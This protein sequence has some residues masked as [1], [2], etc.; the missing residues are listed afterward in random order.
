M[1][2]YRK[3]KVIAKIMRTK[4]STAFICVISVF[5][6]LF[7]VYLSYSCHSLRQSQED[8]ADCYAKHIEIVDSLYRD[9]TEYNKDVIVKSRII[10]DTALLDTL[11]GSVD[12]SSNQYKAL[13][14]LLSNHYDEMESLHNKYD[15]KL[16]RDSLRLTSEHE[17]LRG[18]TKA[19]L[20]IH[21]NRIDHEYNNI[22]IW[23]AVLTIL[24]LVFSFYSIYKMDELI[25]QG[26][27]SVNEIKRIKKTG[28]QLVSEMRGKGDSLLSETESKIV[29]FISM[30]E[31]KILES[32]KTI[33]KKNEDSELIY[34]NVISSLNSS[35]EYFDRQSAAI[36]D[37]FKNRTNALLED[38]SREFNSIQQEFN[39]LIIHSSFLNKV[40]HLSSEHEENDDTKKEE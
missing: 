35:K 40:Q 19:M 1:N 25:K 29:S 17:L 24:F 9:W 14:S 21:L 6:L 3:K 28:E 4:Y 5:I 12:L 32:V 26:H 22:T 23:A 2:D 30:Q 36:L 8:I 34:Q 18:Q 15:G 38:K 7:I 27:D 33:S 20:D 16:L 39:D 31:T 13:A 11:L 37:D 10:N